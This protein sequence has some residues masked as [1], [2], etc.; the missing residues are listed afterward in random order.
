MTSSQS[1]P[2]IIINALSR[3]IPAL[4]TRISSLPKSFFTFSTN[5]LAFKKSR[6][7]SWKAVA[8]PPEA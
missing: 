3:V 1:G 5:S 7:S 6:T 4:F 2:V 8:L